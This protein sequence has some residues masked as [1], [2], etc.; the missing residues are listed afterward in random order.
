MMIIS[1]RT[2]YFR[3]PPWSTLQ[4]TPWCVLLMMATHVFGV[5]ASCYSKIMPNTLFK[6]FQKQRNLCKVVNSIPVIVQWRFSDLYNICPFYNQCYV[7]YV[8]SDGFILSQIILL[9]TL[10]LTITL[11]LG[12]SYIVLDLF[13]CLIIQLSF[14]SYGTFSSCNML[15]KEFMDCIYSCL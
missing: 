14:H 4:V 6:A 15:F 12:S 11:Y 7:T 2:P 5:S 8:P 13:V 9:K 3:L 1:W 10:L